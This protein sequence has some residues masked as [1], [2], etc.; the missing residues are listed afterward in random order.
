MYMKELKVTFA[1]NV[2]IEIE[3]IPVEL[4]REIVAV[5]LYNKGIISQNQAAQ[6]IGITRR[7]FEQVLIKNG[8]PVTG[9]TDDDILEAIS[10]TYKN[11]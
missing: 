2:D 10:Q 9:D 7:E 4:I 11:L 3:K 6:I 5:N 8:L 1:E